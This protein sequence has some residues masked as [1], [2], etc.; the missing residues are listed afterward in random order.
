MKTFTDTAG[1]AWTVTINV[2]AIKRVR[3]VLDIDLNRVLDDKFKLLAQIVEDPVQLVDVVFV[4]CREQADKAG[5][6]DEDFGR[7][8]AGDAIM[9]AAD[10]FIEALTDFF[11]NARA[12]AMLTALMGK[13]RKVRDLLMDRAEL[14]IQAIDPAK[15]AQA[16]MEAAEKTLMSS[17]SPG[18][19]PASSASIP[20]P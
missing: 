6:K 18:N 12:R 1:R 2:D 11:P 19:S 14:Q 16:Q 9:L 5:V 13:G 7:A 4:L 3:S 8:M 15:E 10:A 17:A 20:A